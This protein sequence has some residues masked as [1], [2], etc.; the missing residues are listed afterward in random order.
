MLMVVMLA[1]LAVRLERSGSHELLP[2]SV[3]L[4]LF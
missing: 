2:V 3:D 1:Q 4:F